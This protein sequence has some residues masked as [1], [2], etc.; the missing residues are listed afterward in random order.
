MFT[1]YEDMKGNAKC[2]NWGGLEVRSHP[3]LLAMSPF[4]RSHMTS[5]SILV[6]TIHLYHFRIIASYLSEVAGFNLPHL[7]LVLLLGVTRWN[8]VK[9]FGFRKLESWA[10]V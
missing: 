9:I 1:H 6:E 3:R 2:K 10:I 5:Y 7:H 8:F 4:D